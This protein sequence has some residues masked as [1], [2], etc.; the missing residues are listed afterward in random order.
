MPVQKPFYLFVYGTL[1]NPSVFRAVL[2]RRMV[3]NADDAQSG[4][5]FLARDAVLNGFKKISPDQ[6]YLYA[7]PEPFG[8]IRGYIIGPLPP[9][10]MQ[11]LRKYEGRN[12]VRQSVV[13]QTNSGDQKAYVFAGNLKQLEH[14]FGYAFHDTLKQEILLR[15]KI[16]SALLEAQK[17]QLKTDAQDT[18]TRR[19][20]AEL[21]G[22]T[23]RDLMRM[24][25]DSGGVGDYTIRHAL[26]DAPLRDYT[27]VRGDPE[28]RALAMNYLNMVV[29]QVMFNQLEEQIRRDFRYELDRMTHGEGFY[30]RT[31]SS[32]AALGVLNAAQG[33]L[34]LLIGDCFSELVFEKCHLVDY[35]KWAIMAS[36][37]FY[38]LPAIRRQLAYIRTHQGGG[39]IP[40]G[41]ELEFSNIGHGVISDPEGTRLRDNRY[42]GLLYFQDFGLDILTWKLGGHIDD[43]HDK[44]SARPR[45]GFFEIAL[46]N[47]SIGQNISKPITNDPWVLNQIIHEARQFYDISPH[48]LHIS[49][50]VGGSHKPKKDSLLPPHI[51]KCL[52][53]VGGDPAVDG[54]GKLRIA[55]LVGDEIIGKDPKPHMLFS[56]VR[57][58]FSRNDDTDGITRHVSGR[59]VQQYRFL[60]LSP[61]IN[62]EPIIAALKGIQLSLAPGSF[63]TSAQYETSEEHRQAYNTIMEWGAR[64]TPLEAASINDFLSCV[65]EG[66]M[67]ERR[68]KPAHN[69]AYIA[70]ALN[71]LRKS[72]N[73]F[74]E[75]AAAHAT[76][77]A[78]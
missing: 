18:V 52:L 78:R 17:E 43:H 32:L 40:L 5:A 6:T 14:S 68:G 8:R 41:T 28:A 77:G 24:H 66:L 10:S 44:A 38:D 64:P 12:Y 25:F 30:E 9:E 33:T 45:R 15:Q 29:R 13:V 46:G 19:A 57:K 21:H 1:M 11:A 27:R 72:L 49:L 20:I 16:E 60:R 34:N 55:R 76:E 47:L 50:Q 75:L 48:S 67:I 31:L 36:D 74:N 51:M 62:Y 3:H 73:A 56:E 58:R 71:Q 53:A 7:V 23:I 59:Y 69:A 61:R 63:L 22:D 2:G 70:W 4:D 65:R 54:E 37:A 26:K 35:V 39:E 42:D